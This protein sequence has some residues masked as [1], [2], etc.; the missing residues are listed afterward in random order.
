MEIRIYDIEWDLENCFYDE[1]PTEF[2]IDMEDFDGEPFEFAAD[3]LD[4]T[5]SKVGATPLSFD[6]ELV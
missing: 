1:M 4:H 2:T 5:G 3:Y 6:F